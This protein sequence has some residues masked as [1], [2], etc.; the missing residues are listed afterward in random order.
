MSGRSKLVGVWVLAAVIA[1]AFSWGAVA[2]VRNQVLPAPIQIPP[3]LAQP[4][5]TAADTTTTI[6]GETVVPVEP[7]T[8][9]SLVTSTT[10]DLNAAGSTSTTAPSAGTSTTTASQAPPVSTT[11]T[12]VASE[13][14]ETSS[15]QLEGGIV[16]ISHSPGIVNFISAVPQPGYSADLSDAG[17]DRVRVRFE[18]ESGASD[19]RAEWKSGELQIVINETG[20]DD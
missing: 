20:E 1:M 6:A 14:S 12:S 2:G 15:H 13:A 17:P 8:L 10:A 4:A 19:F 16:T 9:D 7:E 18:G 3:T 5:S 11:T